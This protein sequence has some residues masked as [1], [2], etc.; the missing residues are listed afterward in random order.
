MAMR[1][2]EVTAK[3]GVVVAEGGVAGDGG[4][5]G[6]KALREGRLCQ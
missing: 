3:W 1:R 5:E 4:V 6:R 2:L